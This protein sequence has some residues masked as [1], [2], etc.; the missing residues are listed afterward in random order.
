MTTESKRPVQSI[1]EPMAFQFSATKDEVRSVL[2]SGEPFFIAKDIC[3]ALDLKNS[4]KA[5]SNLDSDEKADVTISYTSSNGTTQKRK[6]KA[7]NESGLYN[8]IFQSRK[9][10]AKAF[11]KWVTSEVLPAI[12]KKGYYNS[13]NKQADFIDARDVVPNYY[14]LNDYMVTTICVEEGKLWYNINDI[15]RA[16]RT[17]TDASQSAKKLN[18][19][20]QLAIKIHVYGGTHPSWFTNAKGLQLI[21]N[22]SRNLKQS[23]QLNLPL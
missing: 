14:K 18:A 22:G 9:P 13:G 3:E 21:I 7:I 1:N 4:R 15:H 5:T 19:K 10:E 8:L 16:I 12:R 17:T 11:R 23:N 2:I 20:Q 6:M